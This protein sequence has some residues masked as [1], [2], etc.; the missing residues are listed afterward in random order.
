MFFTGYTLK[1]AAEDSGHVSRP[2]SSS[3][4]HHAFTDRSAPL[5]FRGFSR[6]RAIDRLRRRCQPVAQIVQSPS[7]VVAGH[8]IL[9]YLLSTRPSLR[10]SSS[11]WHF[12]TGNAIG[13]IE[14]VT[15]SDNLLT[16]M[17]RVQ[18]SAFITRWDYWVFHPS[19]PGDPV[20]ERCV[21]ASSN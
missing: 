10:S 21:N 2:P 17:N 15:S 7:T 8:L 16:G 19:Y 12:N 9:P 3:H 18:L 4:R 20:S 11:R 5:Q 13:R 1:R 6:R 14:A